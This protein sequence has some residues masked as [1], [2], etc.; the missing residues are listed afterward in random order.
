MMKKF[1][2]MLEINIII[3]SSQKILGVPRGDF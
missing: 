3:N 1:N 2:Y